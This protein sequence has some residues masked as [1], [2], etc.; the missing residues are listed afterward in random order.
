MVRLV[1]LYS[2]STGLQRG[3][4]FLASL[5][6]TRVLSISEIGFYILVQT[7]SQLS[8]PIFTLNLTVALMREAKENPSITRQLLFYTASCI[9][10]L[11]L[12]ILVVVL[13]FGI[14]NQIS[15]GL[16]L[17]SIEAIFYLAFAVLQGR[18]AV[19][20]ILKITLTKTLG[21]LGIIAISYFKLITLKQVLECQIFL[22]LIINIG[23]LFFA[24]NQLESSGKGNKTVQIKEIIKYSLSTLPHTVALWISVS[25]DRILL[26]ILEGDAAIGIYGIAFTIAQ[27]I[28]ILISGL[29][30]S[31]PPRIL[32][33]PDIWRNSE[34][35]IKVS[36]HLALIL[37]SMIT[38][39]LLGWR[40]NESIL[41]LIPT[42]EPII[43]ILISL[44]S[45]AFSFSIYYI[46]FASYMYLNRETGAL[47]FLGIVIGPANLLIM[48]L[49]IKSF[50]MLGASIGLITSYMIFGIAY[51]CVAVRLEPELKRVC[52]PLIQM[53][54]LFTLASIGMALVIRTCC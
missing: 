52:I 4:I 1:L 2:T 50:G 33:H 32:H 35:I 11:F 19:G 29:A 54:I 21:F 7:I 27:V 14:S 28:L 26:G 24:F 43:Y 31:L 30:T 23:A 41:H 16:L 47:S 40:L 38:L 15:F 20:Q 48:F 12:S 46:F 5:I 25:S 18:E 10:I 42:S 53:S 17:G 39:L 9:A 44:I 49:L 8:I 22:G 37:L 45:V 13:S 3:S 36:R 6:L 51:G 34:Y